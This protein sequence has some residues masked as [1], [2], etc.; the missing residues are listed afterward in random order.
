MD[1]RSKIILGLFAVV[2][3]SIIITEI[4]SPKPLNW[5]PSYT[6]ADKIPFGCFVFYNE[7]SQLFSESEITTVEESVYDVL[8]NSDST[9]TSNYFFVN[10]NID[11]DK[12]ETNQLLK[13]AAQGNSVFIAASSFSYFLKDTLNIDI[14]YEYTLLEDTVTVDLTHKD[15]KEENFLF[16]RGINKAHFISVDTLNTT[17]LGH[18]KYEQ[19][20]ELTGSVEEIVR[21]PNFI[22]TNFGKGQFFVNTTPQAFSNYYMLRGNEDYAAHTLSYLNN[23]DLYWDNYK[24]A[25]RV[26]ITSPMRFVLNQTA[27]KWGYYLTMV[28]LLLFVIFKAKREQRIIP[29]INPLE[30]SSVEFARTV[31]SLYHQ[32]K[33]YTDLITKKLSYFLAFLRNRY[34]LDTSTLNEKTIQILAAKSG[35]SLEEVKKL[36]EYIIYLKNKAM[37]SEQNLIELNKKITAFKN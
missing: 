24:K 8:V 7:L 17:V 18:L 31:G 29:V 5:R 32:N 33:D 10:D 23:A 35:K 2:L 22:K 16:S 21:K 36:I 13:Y 9:K 27:L 3:L 37:H 4:T 28:G 19:K 11:L 6:A 26:V 34:Y 30:N 12:Q 25:G 14:D 20:N 1:K 15:F